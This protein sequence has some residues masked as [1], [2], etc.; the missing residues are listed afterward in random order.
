MLNLA[1]RLD[2][3]EPLAMAQSGQLEESVYGVVDR[4]DAD[5]TPHF[6]RRWKGRIGAMAPT[7][8]EPTIFIIEK[9]E[10]IILKH[11][12]YKCMFGG[13]AGTK[14]I[15]AMDAMSG[16]VNSCGSKVFVLRERMKSLKE[17]VY[18]GI[19]DR[20]KELNV[21]GFAPYPSLWEIRHKTGGKF[22]FGGLRNVIDMKGS[23][24]YK[25]FFME[26]A[27]RTSQTTIDTLG[28]TLRSV[29]G[30][31]LWF[32]WNPE[33]AN[34]PMSLEFITPYQD[35]LDR[36]GYYEDEFYLIIKVGYSDN[37]WFEHDESLSSELKKD[38][39]KVESGLMSKSRFNHIW[40]GAFSDDVTNSVIEADWFDACIDAHKNLG[41][42]GKGAVVA[43]H[44]PADVG[45]D[46]KGLAIRKGVVFTKLQ[47]IQ[48]EDAN[49][50]FDIACRE[51]KQAGCDTF[52]WDADG[53]GA[54]LR[55]QAGKNFHGT[56]VHTVMYKGSESV[57]HPE[58]IFKEAADYSIQAQ[59]KNKDVFANKKAQNIIS[60]AS[61]C[62]RTYDA[63]VNGNYHDPDT[64]VSFASYNEETGEGIDSR[65]MAKFRAECCKMPLKPAD[66]IKFYTKE[67]MRKGMLQP[68]GSR[69]KIPSGNLV[70]SAVLSFDFAG[71]I[72]N[73]MIDKSH[74]P[75]SRKVMRR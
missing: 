72:N 14:S 52:L 1:R 6:I 63:V 65:T 22:T 33:S 25:Y 43:G 69:I 67:E 47:E 29:P 13:R 19:N 7:D 48:A 45:K 35:A 70:D 18:A 66:T 39:S 20:I 2:A 34:D 61:R 10:P 17:S 71:I 50:G 4:V 46:A 57:H 42:E 68:D 59:K 75:K 9:L 37:P 27:A 15:A 49:R 26:E 64:L 55:D 56:S 28:P 54:L 24:K 3:I 12:K 40:E 23:F 41:F 58:A 74:R 16:D 51:S 11:K 44:D 73:N 32:V 31:E 62:R 53:M 38:K 21:S 36:D 8:E 30:A 60:F 5:G